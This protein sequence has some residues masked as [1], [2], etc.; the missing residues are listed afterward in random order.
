MPALITIGIIL[1]FFV[2]LL[3]LKATVTIVYAG[4]VQ[5]FLRVLFVK[6][7]LVPAKK[8]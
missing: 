2:F 3:T 5:L 7:K 6:I 1:L 8:K 4:E